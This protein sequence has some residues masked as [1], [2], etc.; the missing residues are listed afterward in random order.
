[1][2]AAIITAYFVEPES[3]ATMLTLDVAPSQQGMVLFL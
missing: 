1:M 2:A 3:L